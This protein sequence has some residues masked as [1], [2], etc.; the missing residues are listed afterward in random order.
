MNPPVAWVVLT[1]ACVVV[2][3]IWV[4]VWLNYQP[5]IGWT[6]GSLVLSVP[7]WVGVHALIKK[8]FDE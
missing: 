8:R 7:L 3:S 6:I 4:V 5:W 2:G 1:L